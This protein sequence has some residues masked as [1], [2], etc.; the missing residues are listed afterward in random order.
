MPK[1]DGLAILPAERILISL[2][3]WVA[4]HLLSRAASPLER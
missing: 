1:A 3:Q 4:A 2:G